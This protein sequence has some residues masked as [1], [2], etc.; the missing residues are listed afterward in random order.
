MGSGGRWGKVG[1]RGRGG[2]VGGEGV[3]D[4][5]QQSTSM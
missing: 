5:E 3:G 2:G 1:S 4:E